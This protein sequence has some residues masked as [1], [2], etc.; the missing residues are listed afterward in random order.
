MYII[1]HSASS[2]M[3]LLCIANYE[4][5][6]AIA[7]W[8]VTK[9]VDACGKCAP[10]HVFND[11]YVSVFHTCISSRIFLVFPWVVVWFG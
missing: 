11:I 10:A 3:I 2:V 4:H 7:S 1:S 9:S 5:M 8:L 6:H